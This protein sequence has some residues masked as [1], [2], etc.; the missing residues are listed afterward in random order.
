MNRISRLMNTVMYLMYVDLRTILFFIQYSDPLTHII[1]KT[2]ENLLIF[3]EFPK[4]ITGGSG[5]GLCKALPDN[6]IVL[7]LYK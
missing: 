2:S 7:P 5:P 3:S 4:N 6:F 1:K